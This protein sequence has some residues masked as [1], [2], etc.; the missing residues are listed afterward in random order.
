MTPDLMG[1]TME[2]RKKDT[3]GWSIYVGKKYTFSDL[4]GKMALFLILL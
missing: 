2:G 4:T 3:H 1:L